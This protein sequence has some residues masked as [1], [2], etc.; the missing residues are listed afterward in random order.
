MHGGAYSNVVV[1]R[2]SV[3]PSEDH[4]FYQRLVYT[5]LRHLPGIDRA[6]A[7]AS[8]RPLDTIDPIVLST[9]RVGTAELTRM[10]TEPHAAVNEAV[11]A[12]PKRAHHARGFVNAVLR[13]IAT[14]PTGGP[15]GLADCYPESLVE[16]VV[17]DLGDDAGRAF[18]A[19]ANQPAERGVRF[20]PGAPESGARYARRGEDVEGW[21]AAGLVDVIDPASS[22]VAAAVEARPGDRI[23]DLAAAPGGKTRA[24]ADE[25]GGDGRIVAMDSHRRRVA[26]ARR[27]SHHVAGIDWVVGDATAPPLR[28]HSFDRVLLDAPCTGLGTVRRRPEIRYRIAPDAPERYGRLQRSMIE[29][30]IELVRP[31]GRLVYS[32]CTPFAAETTEVVAGLG[33]RA[34]ADTRAPRYGDGVLMGPDTTGTDGMFIAVLDR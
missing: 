34:P 27:R 1:A 24:L 22:A 18:L 25:L 10:G 11:A 14:T 31:G 15:G 9:V 28:E 5:T 20:R 7:G 19:A 26:R 32:V 4:A 16:R 29:R 23:A 30:A 8:T 6:V 2:T 21:E 3:E 33:F 12:L 17:T 13:R